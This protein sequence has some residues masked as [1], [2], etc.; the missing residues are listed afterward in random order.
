MAPSDGLDETQ[1]SLTEHLGELRARIVKAL[2][3]LAVAALGCGLFV[4]DLFEAAIAPIQ[5]VLADK[6]RVETLLVAPDGPGAEALGERLAGMKRVRLVGRTASIEDAETRALAS[7][8]TRRPLDLVVVSAAALEPG[9]MVGDTGE[10]GARFSVVYLV[11]DPRDPIVA[12][13][14]LEGATVLLDPPRPAALD[15]AIRRAAAA[16]GKAQAGDRLVVLSPLEPFFAYV[17]VAL[18]CALFLACPVWIYQAW[19]FVAPGLYRHER[20]FVLP[21]VL[22]ASGLFVGGGAFAYFALFPLMFDVLVNQFLPDSLA[23]SFTVDNYLGL[24][25]RVTVAFGVVSELPL[26]M[27]LASA[28]GMVTASTLRKARKIAIVG[29]FVVG[30]LLTPADPISMIMMAVPLLIFFEL[31]VI[32]AALLEPKTPPAPNE[33]GLAPVSED[34]RD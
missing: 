11:S 2:I 17:K 30:A 24:L 25:L 31:G 29:S 28:F 21:V 23:G 4:E 27:A 10:G 20:R 26:A 12:E 34:R 8:R 16:A 15:R 14:Q 6:A 7:A 9:S 32:L 22:S 33:T 18:V 3:G 13:L 5:A 19:S 1:Y